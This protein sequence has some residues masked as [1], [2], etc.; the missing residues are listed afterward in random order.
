MRMSVLVILLLVSGICFALDCA[1]NAYVQSCKVCSFDASGKMN[2]TCYNGW[3]EWGKKCIAEKR[4]SLSSAYSNGKCP[5]VDACRAQ[6]ESC[7]NSMSAGSDQRDCLN[8]LVGECFTEAD[9]CVAKAEDTC[10][11]GL[12]SS[13][14]AFLM[15]C[16]F[17]VFMVLLLTAGFVY[18]KTN[19]RTR[20]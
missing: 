8:P 11:A 13:I 17:P 18:S 9:A 15:W 3:Q 14:D 1:A 7:K 19:T 4:P 12:G 2:Q 6:L 20:E 16:P 10:D 5:E